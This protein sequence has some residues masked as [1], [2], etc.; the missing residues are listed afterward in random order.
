MRSE[1]QSPGVHD[2]ELNKMT[3]IGKKEIDND[4]ITQNERKRKTE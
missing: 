2:T 3:D 1:Q 4:T